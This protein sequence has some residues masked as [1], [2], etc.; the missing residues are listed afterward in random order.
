MPA[1]YYKLGLEKL[2]CLS[3]RRSITSSETSAMRSG[4]QIYT[5][6]NPRANKNEW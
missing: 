1:T 3:F 2:Y 6:N 5:L 4:Q